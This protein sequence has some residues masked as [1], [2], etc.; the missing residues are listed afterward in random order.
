MTCF[1]GLHGI[2]P[3]YISNLLKSNVT[4][5]SLR[6]SS[7]NLLMIPKTNSIYGDRSFAVAAPTEWNRMPKYLRQIDSITHFK[8]SLKTYL[9]KEYF[10][11]VI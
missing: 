9:F 11:P 5:R 4:S 7:Q 2:A 8:T 1:K 10:Y 6:S 3:A